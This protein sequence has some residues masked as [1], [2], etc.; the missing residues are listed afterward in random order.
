[1]RRFLWGCCVLV[2]VAACVDFPAGYVPPD[3]GPGYADGPELTK[4]LTPIHDSHLAP[5]S[6]MPDAW[7]PPTPDSWRPPDQGPI[8]PTSNSGQ[9]CSGSCPSPGEECLALSSTSSIGMCLGKCSQPGSPCPVANSATQLSVCAIEDPTLSQFYCI[10]FCDVQG[11]TFA[12][13]DPAQNGC[14]AVDP[15]QPTIKVCVPK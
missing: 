5:D 1:M 13:P 4:F 8:V 11:Q 7:V 6:W 15:T 14:E 10:Y 2:T 12:C 9:L 3:G